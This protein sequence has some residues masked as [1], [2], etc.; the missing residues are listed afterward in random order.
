MQG[1][2]VWLTEL[3]I[4]LQCAVDPTARAMLDVEHR[5]F[6]NWETYYLSRD[7]A[8]TAFRQTP[9]E[10]TGPVTDPVSRERFQPS[11]DS[12]RRD[13]EE[14]TFFFESEATLAKFDAD[15]A[16]YET[17]MVGMVAKN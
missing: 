11:A 16:S 1:P 5:V 10:F 7:A 12:P 13:A 6:V 3:G 4:E 17:L 14:R 15:P 9:W 2:E 8:V